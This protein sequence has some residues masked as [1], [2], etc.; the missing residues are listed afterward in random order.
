MCRWLNLSCS[1]LRPQARAPC[2]YRR[3]AA[4]MVYGDGMVLRNLIQVVYV[5]QTLVFHLRIVEEVAFDPS[6]GGRLAR[7]IA[8]LV[9]N[10]ADGHELHFERITDQDFIEQRGPGR[11]VV[12]V[13]EA[14]Y[15]RHLPGIDRLG[16]FRDESLDIG[17]SADGDKPAAFHRQGLGAACGPWCRPWR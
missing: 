11:V 15:D 4:A 5:Q 8:E 14:R 2:C 16:P 3:V 7:A 6:A 17:G 13:G 9:D 10:A 1:W 12:A